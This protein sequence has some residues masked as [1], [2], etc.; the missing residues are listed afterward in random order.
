MIQE[1]DIFLLMRIFLA[2]KPSPRAFEDLIGASKQDT[3]LRIL[4]NDES[5]NNILLPMRDD[6]VM[7]HDRRDLKLSLEDT[8]WI[9]ANLP[10]L[11]TTIERLDGVFSWYDLYIALLRDARLEAALMTLPGE[12]GRSDRLRRVASEIAVRGRPPLPAPDSLREGSAYVPVLGSA[13]GGIKAGRDLLKAISEGLDIQAV[14]T[15]LQDLFT[16]GSADIIW[17]SRQLPEPG[18]DT[19]KIDP[20]IAHA[21]RYMAARCYGRQS[22]HDTAFDLTAELTQDTTQVEAMPVGDRTRL[23]KLHTI[24][25]LRSGRLDYAIATCRRMVTRY[26]G[27]WEYYYQIGDSIAH[28]DPVEAVRYFRQALCF[29]EKIPAPLR[30]AMADFLHDQGHQDEATAVILTLLKDEKPFADV[31]AAL[32]NSAWR[33]GEHDLWRG[34]LA[35]YFE[36]QGLTSD[37][38]RLGDPNA[39]FGI[40]EAHHDRRTDHDL[41]T[42]IMTSW[43]AQATLAKAV[44]SV[45]NQTL[46]NIEILIVD[47]VSSDGTRALIQDLAAQDSRIRYLFNTVN[48]GTYCSKN[49]GIQ[50]AR[51]AYITFHDSDDW[52]HPQRLERHLA[53]TT[54]PVMMSMSNWVRMTQEGRIMVRKG[55]GYQHKNPAS[56]FMRRG[57]FEALGLFDSVRTGADT[58][59][60][61]RIRNHFGMASVRDMSDVLG[62]GL[63]H[64]ASL[65]TLG[66]SAF[67]ALRYSPVRLKYWESWGRWHL[68]QMMGGDRIHIPYPYRDRAF[69][70]PEEIVVR[71]FELG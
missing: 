13:S 61:W 20:A 25:A 5:Y 17:L 21:I 70:A 46:A 33:R 16:K 1:S 47:D 65:T 60:L 49:R 3:A 10:L 6:G 11:D 15:R 48:V 57:V 35:R 59:M 32:A 53:A 50:Q 4:I 44:A 52:M 62:I 68:D 7:L 55:G 30:I 66:T 14:W 27:D 69:E 34:H 56:T 40:G 41:I 24:S 26:P 67:D 31:H 58:E 43:N 63:H 23:L 8:D 37:D 42:V 39:L 36:V 19:A 51:G 54:G 28:T 45:R 22:M 2:R 71:Q 18:D 64:E 12:G 9:A 29:S 38:I